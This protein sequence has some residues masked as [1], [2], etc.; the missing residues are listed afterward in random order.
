MIDNESL[1]V[2]CSDYFLKILLLQAEGKRAMKAE[3]WVRELIKNLSLNLFNMDS[4]RYHAF[5]IVFEFETFNLQLKSIRN[6]YY[7]K[8]TLLQMTESELWFC[9]MKSFAG[10]NI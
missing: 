3:D 1:F 6:A 9:Q 5:R 10:R 8:I 2:S 7:K 4:A